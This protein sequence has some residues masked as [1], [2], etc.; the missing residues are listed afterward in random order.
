VERD[1]MMHGQG[2]GNHR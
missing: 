1:I 2:T